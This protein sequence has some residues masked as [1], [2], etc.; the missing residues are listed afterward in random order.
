MDG[1][2]NVLT[3]VVG[4]FYGLGAVDVDPGCGSWVRGPVRGQV[5][6]AHRPVAQEVSREVPLRP[7]RAV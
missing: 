4:A 1:D 5:V 2:L 6:S 3:A 7:D